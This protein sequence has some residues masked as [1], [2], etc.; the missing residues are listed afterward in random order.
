MLR[1]AS[2]AVQPR[3][4][5]RCDIFNPA[6]N[7]FVCEWAPVVHVFVEQALGPYDTPPRPDIMFVDDGMHAWGANASFEPGSG[8][9][10]LSSVVEN[11]P[12]M[13]LEKLTHEFIHA[14]LAG[15]PEGDPFYEEG[16][17]DFSTWV[18]AHAPVWGEH[19]NAMIASAANNIRI[20]RDRAM[21][22]KSDYDRKRWA[23]G[24]LAMLTKGPHII[25]VFRLKKMENDRTW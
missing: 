21:L 9:V 5:F 11:N 23:G 4:Q 15:W 10:R 25:T 13:T 22:D 19:R 1:T 2:M 7:T 12:G 6:W 24:L 17:V 16:V 18:L 3:M 8:Q 14:S 20:R